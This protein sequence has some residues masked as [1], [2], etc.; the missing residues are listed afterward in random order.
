MSDHLSTLPPPTLEQLLRDYP[1]LPYCLRPQSWTELTRSPEALF[2]RDMDYLAAV[3]AVFE[4]WSAGEEAKKNLRKVFSEP[5]KETTQQGGSAKGVDVEELNRLIEAL[6]GL[7]AYA[8]YLIEAR[9]EQHRRTGALQPRCV[10]LAQRLGLSE[11]ET[12]AMAFVVLT[13]GDMLFDG[14][15]FYFNAMLNYCEMTLSEGLNFIS[16]ERM[17]VQE[18]ILSPDE[19]DPV[20][21]YSFK[22]PYTTAGVLAGM[23]LSEEQQL[24]I[25]KT[26]L[27]EVVCE[28]DVAGKKYKLLRSSQA[29]LSTSK[30]GSDDEEDKEGDDDAEEKSKE[31][32]DADSDSENS[33]KQKEK[34]EEDVFDILRMEVMMEKEY[35]QSADEPKQTED[36]EEDDSGL[37]PYT[38]NVQYL[39]DHIDWLAVK[40]RVINMAR[41][42]EEDLDHDPKQELQLRELRAKERML[43]GKCEKRVAMTVA[44]NSGK[45]LPR[46]ERLALR[47]NLEPFER[48]I[49]LTLVANVISPKISP[50]AS[51][52]H[53]STNVQNFS[54]GALLSTFCNSFEEE[55]KNRSYFY[56]NARLVREGIIRLSDTWDRELMNTDVE[57]DRRMLDFIVGLDSE[58]SEL[59]EGS[60]LYTPNVKLES[61]ILPE[62]QKSLIVN[63]VRNFDKFTSISKKL[64]VGDTIA[65]GSVAAML[66]KR[67]LLINYPSLGFMQADHVIKFIFRE[68][69]LT[70]S[71]LF[72][73]ECE[74]IFMS[75]DKTSVSGVN[76]LLTEIERHNGLIIMATNRAFDLDEAMHRRITLAIEF[77]Q[78]DP[79]LR[80]DIWRLL[81]PP[82]VK[83]AKDVD[84]QRLA[85]KYELTGG[86]IKNAILIALSQA[87]TRE[88]D[89]PVITQK[90]LEQ[91]AINQLRGRLAMVDFD[92][93]IVPTRGIEDITATPE[94]L[95]QLERI[96]QMEKASQIL[97]SEWGY[98]EKTFNDQG[99]TC[100]F[101]GPPGTG[102]TLAAEV[103]GFETGKPLKMVNA[104]QL[105]DKYVG[106]TGKH[107]EE[108]FK[109]AKSLDAILVFDDAE[110]LFGARHTDP[111]SSTDRYANLDTSILLYHI[112]RFPGI[113]I[114]TT[115]LIDTIDQAFFR[116]FRFAVKFE[117]PNVA[118]REQL[119]RQLLPPKA[120]L[121]EDIDFRELAEKF[122]FSGGVIK[123]CCYK[124]AAFA[125][126]RREPEKRC[127]AM[128]DLVAVA[129]EELSISPSSGAAPFGMFG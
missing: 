39:S 99:T 111:S 61:V 40:L 8:K 20:S 94:V 58:L 117:L 36:G 120:P 92:R 115:N 101:Y 82:M 100:L 97:F 126:L 81:M 113:T 1:K 17:H 29:N 67:I 32:A 129:E 85:L 116:R 30:T 19:D 109:E 121:K 65:Y 64:S 34:E 74:T 119:W 93:R 21:S 4:V 125:A 123:N 104:S 91:G 41:E 5:K 18:G 25:D 77:R 33:Q 76:L 6:R 105:V 24:K 98:S 70:D 37:F 71:V 23:E 80:A 127:I 87:V 7:H 11:K 49:L 63:T 108:V 53:R 103:I 90:D 26:V 28:E 42:R 47:L 60:H 69:K 66:D 83:L 3:N 9:L 31:D 2:L 73:D 114:L 110:A 52:Y 22:I 57:L 16:A 118:Q 88:G 50:D 15:G 10:R 35:L 128:A 27:A 54:V 46:L 59:V 14:T 106:E 55:L 13:Y 56:K 124:A 79:H 95:R 102:K 44:R 68:A 78:P 86:F 84:F 12:Y 89:D 107:I 51:R 38:N 96:I 122:A 43:K 75:R 62:D 112:E 45:W 48:L 72:F